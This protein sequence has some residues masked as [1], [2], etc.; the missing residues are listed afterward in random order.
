MLY[1]K[2]YLRYIHNIKDYL[3]IKCNNKALKYCIN[4]INFVSLQQ[5][6]ITLK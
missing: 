5:K 2:H 1:I 4:G 3:T 6:K